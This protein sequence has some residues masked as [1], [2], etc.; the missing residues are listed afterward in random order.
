MYHE[1]RY[2]W[3]NLGI[4]NLNIFEWISALLVLK[5][6]ANNTLNLKIGVFI[7][8]KQWDQDHIGYS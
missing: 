8:L 2:S 7:A 1:L 6:I 4:A 5:D 3:T